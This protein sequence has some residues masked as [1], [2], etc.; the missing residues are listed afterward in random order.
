VVINLLSLRILNNVSAAAVRRVGNKGLWILAKS[1][2]EVQMTAYT[3]VCR[4][5]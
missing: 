1:K 5:R 4:A 2:G 3:V